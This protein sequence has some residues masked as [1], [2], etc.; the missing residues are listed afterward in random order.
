MAIL[1][2]YI[3]NEVN[4]NYNTGKERDMSL[5][6]RKL[7]KNLTLEEKTALVSGTDFMFTNPVPRLGIPSLRTSDGPHGLRVQ[8][9]GGDNGVNGS[10]PATA[11]ATAACTASGWNPKNTFKMGAA[12]AEECLYYGVDVLLGPAI[13]I[14]R[15]P[16]CG[17]N[18]EYF[19]EDPYLAGKMAAGAVKGVQSKGVGVCVK[20]FALNGAENF[21]FMGD[22]VCDM[23]TIRE[24]YLK[25]F[26][27][28]VKESKPHSLMCAYNK[29]N[30]TY[31][32]EN[33]WLLSDV[34]RGEWGFDGLV[35]SDWGATH[36]RV[37][38]IAAGL[39]LEMPGDT[40]ICR[41]WIADAVKDGTL[42]EDELDKAVANVLRLSERYENNRKG[43]EVDWQAHHALSAEIAEDCAVLLKNDG[44]LPLAIN[45]R[46]FVAGDLFGKMRFQGAGSSMIDSTFITSPKDAFDQ[47][48]AQY[49]FCRG[50]A[51]N[52]LEPDESL[53][54][55]AIDAAA[56]F[57]SVLVFAGLTDYVE[58]E[59]AERE[60]MR[61][62]QNQLALIDAFLQAGKK[63][64]VVLFGGSPVELPFADRVSAILNMYLPGQNGGTAAYNLLFGIKTP[65]G[66][67]AETWVKEYSDVPFGDAYSKT[68]NEIYKESVLVGYRY[69]LTANKEVRYPFGYGL[70]YTTF[71]YSD[72]QVKETES[73]YKISCEIVNNG[74]Y[75]GAEVVQLYVKAP[76]GVFKPV[77]ELKGF[78]KVYLKAGERKR[79]EIAVGKEE[80]R[81]WNVAEEKWV[82]EG[83][84]YDLQI[85]SDCQTVKL[86]E[87]VTLKGDN[88]VF[89][90]SERINGIYAGAQ[91]SLADDCVFEEMSGLSIPAV[92][93]RNTITLES[94]FSDMQESSFMG[95]ILYCAVL[96]MAK[97]KM[98]RAKRLPEGA[99]RD[100]KIKGATFLKRILESSSIISMT[101][102]A[103]KRF[104]YNFAEGFVNFGNRR[105]WKGVACFLKR[106]KAPEI[107]KDK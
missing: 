67:L 95:K 2:N 25:A 57:E 97:K 59:G 93:P 34:L 42:K 58:S 46:V 54:A 53:I 90:Y 85:C 78:A 106:I 49:E 44:A 47:H 13:N 89:P 29:I 107:P 104:P 98:K 103:G 63:V 60:N 55:E 39:D 6:V 26:E 91:L 45:E 43:V 8:K 96:G 100:N 68:V 94:R 24:I 65:C 52:K 81:Y 19:S 15:N 72:M 3:A 10:E 17:R 80:L 18:F 41:K 87:S 38:G 71:A 69:Y 92:P 28:V 101:M 35:M 77:R 88:A 36:D 31:C 61:L 51:E 50:Y 22:S 7:L 1:R 76:Q 82:T 79:V 40:A 83:G 12:M 30:G 20:H 14:K 102:C 70:S 9:E 64:I 62:P 99:E 5:K 27:I 32:C 21:R 16:L 56:E 74:N 66:K 33:K 48:K 75:D 105:F 4:L 84:E 23:R 86:T 37:K 11:W 73:E